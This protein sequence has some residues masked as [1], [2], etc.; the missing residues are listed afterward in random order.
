MNNIITSINV[1][2]INFGF[3]IPIRKKERMKY[4]YFINQF[5]MSY[6]RIN[7]IRII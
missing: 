1:R 4:I 5:P 7:Y 6:K 2:V 3:Y